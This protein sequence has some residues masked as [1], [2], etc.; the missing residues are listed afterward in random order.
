MA[1]AISPFFKRRKGKGFEE[2]KRREKKIVRKRRETNLGEEREEGGV[3]GAWEMGMKTMEEGARAGEWEDTEEDKEGEETEKEEK[4]E[5]WEGVVGEWPWGGER[6][7][8]EG[9]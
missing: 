6:G 2:K 3:E 4:V 1:T 9:D 5:S 8:R 7:G